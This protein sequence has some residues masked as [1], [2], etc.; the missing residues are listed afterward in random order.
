MIDEKAFEE[1][2]T[3]WRKHG[4]TGLG[5]RKN[6]EA[7][8]FALYKALPER[9]STQPDEY[10]AFKDAI[11]RW[12]GPDDFGQYQ[13]DSGSLYWLWGKA[14]EWATT[15]EVSNQ[16]L[17]DEIYDHV[18]FGRYDEALNAANTRLYDKIPKTDIEGGASK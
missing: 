5:M 7:L 1:F 14:V 13:A 4:S 3:A 10:A 16:A 8:K 6:F 15:R 17:L 9:E 18:F 11:K 12:N 2:M